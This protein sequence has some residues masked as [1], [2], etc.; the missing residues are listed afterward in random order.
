MKNYLTLAAILGAIA[1]VS[2]SF[3]AQA[4]PEAQ[5][6]MQRAASPAVPVA[7]DIAAEAIAEPVVDPEVSD[8]D[9]CLSLA[10]A[11]NAEGH[12]PTAAEKDAAFAACMAAREKD[13][14]EVEV[15][16]APEEHT[17]EAGGGAVAPQE[18]AIEGT[19]E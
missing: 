13:K 14:A 16:P 6:A 7:N 11:P 9:E 4:E 8:S 12:E 19:K 3:L 2:V 10:A 15:A 5:D 1:F 17:G 18:G